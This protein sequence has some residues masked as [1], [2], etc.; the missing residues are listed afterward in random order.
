MR[1]S[2]TERHTVILSEAKDLCGSDAE[3]R[4]SIGGTAWTSFGKFRHKRYRKHA[5]SIISTPLGR[6]W[7]ISWPSTPF[8]ACMKG[9]PMPFM[10]VTPVKYHDSK[11]LGR[12][13]M[14]HSAQNADSESQGCR[15][16]HQ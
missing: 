5:F 11:T 8:Q 13:D 1:I 2:N 12:D 3:L 16:M 4:V 10:Q 6:V 14:A 15:I 7:S 9:A